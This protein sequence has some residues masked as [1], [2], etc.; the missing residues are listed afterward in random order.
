MEGNGEDEVGNVPNGFHDAEEGDC[1]SNGHSDKGNPCGD[2]GDA[3]GRPGSRP[4]EVTARM[5]VPKFATHYKMNHKKRGIALIFNHEVFECGG[6]KSRAGTN[7][8]SKNFKE[9][10]EWL[11]FDV[12]VFKDLNYVELEHQ[13]RQA[14]AMDHSDH[15]CILIAVLSHGEMGIVYAKDTPYKPDNLWAPFTADRCPTLAGKPKMFFLQACQGDKLDGGV[16]LLALSRT[17]T[18]GANP[19]TY[20]I[21]AHADFIIVHSTVKGYYSWRNTTKGS[22]FIQALCYE[23]RHRALENDLLTILTYV[24][25]RIAVDFESN[26]PDSPTMHRQKQIPCVMSMLTRLIQF[27]VPG[28]SSEKNSLEHDAENTKNA[29]TGCSSS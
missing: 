17:E 18:D 14:A 29:V 6:L 27:N 23:L 7:E 4:G 10:L 1:T 12:H 26:V 22:W 3:L 13:V 8:D 2:E 9:C 11:G 19:N 16:H 20:K 15:D 21:P 28:G 5:P 25:H 24:S